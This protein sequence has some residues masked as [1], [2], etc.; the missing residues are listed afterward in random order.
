ML[1]LS[2]LMKVWFVTF[3]AL[4]LVVGCSSGNT[5]GNTGNSAANNGTSVSNE[6]P[7]ESA[8]NEEKLDISIAVRYWGGSPSWTDDHP[9]IKYLNDKF[10]IN[11]KLLQINGPDY[12][13]K[14]KVM[15]ASGDLPDLYNIATPSMYINWQAEGAF[16]D[17]STRLQ[18]YPN[19]SKTFSEDDVAVRVLNPSDKL[20]GLPEISWIAR[21]TIQIRKDWLDNLGLEL[22]SADEFTI[23]KFYEIAKA[24]ATQDANQNGIKDEIGFAIVPAVMTYPLKYAFGIANGWTEKDGQLIPQQIQVDEW[25]AYLTFLNKAYQEGVLDQD[26][27]L[28]NSNDVEEMIKGNRLGLFLFRNTYKQLV[29]EIKKT[30]PETEPEV[31][32]MAPPIGPNGDRGNGGYNIGLTKTVINAKASDAKIDRILQILDWW[33]TE[34]GTSVMKNGIEGVHYEKNAQGEYVITD[35]WEPDLPRNLNSNLFHRPGTDLNI[36]LWSDEQ[37]VLDHQEYEAL[38][39]KY[40]VLNE[41]MGLEFYSDTYQKKAADLDAKFETA[42]LKIIVGDQPIEYIE[43][44]SAEWLAGGGDQI[45]KEINEAAAR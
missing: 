43:Q 15:A 9:T 38:A 21:D 34:E 28:R 42:L 24:F 5:N 30:F 26:F 17:L 6:K 23:D 35:R 10:N 11:I 36:Y 37:D 44:A 45:I 13:E 1:S 27:A 33:V 31:I 20:Y 18:N 40:V 12:D 4:T 16:A 25:K 41:A 14:L 2:K 32:P 19:L 7:S 22:P 8:K 29:G 39:K 3:L